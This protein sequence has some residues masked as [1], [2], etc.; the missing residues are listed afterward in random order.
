VLITRAVDAADLMTEAM[1][2]A[3]RLATRPS[4]AVGL[5]KRAVRIGTTL[6]ADDGLAYEMLAFVMS[7]LST[8]ARKRGAEYIARFRAGTSAR[9]ILGAWREGRLS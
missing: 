9:E 2:L 1:A 7:G 5:A 6:P 4:V 8:E 3:H